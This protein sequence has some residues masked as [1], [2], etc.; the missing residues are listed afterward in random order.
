MQLL[1]LESAL[2]RIEEKSYQRDMNLKLRVDCT[3]QEMQLIIRSI[4]TMFEMLL[5]KL[6]LLEERKSI[7]VNSFSFKEKI[8]Y[9]RNSIW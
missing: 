8:V 5:T 1:Q 2:K 7:L 6:N 9:L 3:S 4:D